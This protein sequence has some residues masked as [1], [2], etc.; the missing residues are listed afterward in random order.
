MSYRL[1]IRRLR[2]LLP[3]ATVFVGIGFSQ[4]PDPVSWQSKLTYHA[5][6]AYGPTALAES[7]VYAGYLQEVNHPSEWGQ[8]ADGYAKRLGSTLAYSGIRNALAF[9]MDTTL[10]QD[11]R[12]YRSG[13]GG[14]WLRTKHVVRGTFLTR[15]DSGGETLATW[16][17]GSAY[18][19]A[20]LSNEWYPGR[21][22]TVKLSL[23]QGSAQIGFDM[24]VNLG[25]EFW[26]DLK[27]KMLRR[28]P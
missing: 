26:P 4:A 28:K 14:V 9:G 19:A 16:R 11:P 6:K 13:E 21:L 2:Y 17:L 3:V 10:H 20:F 1:S 15:K 24:L 8:G 5:L 18:G 12:Y 25:S 27:S 23:E 22:N 7:T